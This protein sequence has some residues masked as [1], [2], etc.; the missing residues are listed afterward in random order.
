[1]GNSPLS[2][3]AIGGLPVGAD[4]LQK[5][6][7]GP[8]SRHA[9]SGVRVPALVHGLICE[10]SRLAFITPTGEL[11]QFAADAGDQRSR[12]SDGRSDL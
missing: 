12:C 3:Q 11:Q 9:A 5:P 6:A 7:W 10:E 1:M 4:D 2:R 8:S